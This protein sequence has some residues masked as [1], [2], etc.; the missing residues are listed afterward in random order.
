[1]ILIS[2]NQGR[3]SRWRCQL[4]WRWRRWW[5]KSRWN[6]NWSMILRLSDKDCAGHGD[7]RPADC[8]DSP[9][10]RT[11]SLIAWTQWCRWW[12]TDCDSKRPQT[13]PCGGGGHGGGGGGRGVSGQDQQCL[14]RFQGGG[15]GAERSRGAPQC[16]YYGTH[17]CRQERQMAFEIWG[18]C[19]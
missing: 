19:Q 12:G 8:D 6:P 7:T 2:R 18:G 11:V 15:T 1:M 5:W 3:I 14:T 16:A 17:R 9:T 13:G 10:H 4:W